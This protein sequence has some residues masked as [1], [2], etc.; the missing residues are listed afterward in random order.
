V[1]YEVK[2][3]TEQEQFRNDILDSVKTNIW[4]ALHRHSVQIPF[5]IRT[6]QL[7][8]QPKHGKPLV[9]TH[10]PHNVLRVKPFFQ[11]LDEEEM[12]RL[13]CGARM[14]RFG[15]GEKIIVQGDEGK[16]MF[17]LVHGSAGV[18]VSQGGG[19][20]HQIATLR[21]G[22]YFGEMSLLTGDP[23]TATIVAQMDCDVLEI[24]KVSFGEIVAENPALLDRLSEVLTARRLEMDG[25]LASKN[26][27]KQIESLQQEYSANLLKRI[28]S[29]FEL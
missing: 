16:S 17:V 21:T 2:F 3:W 29:F 15:R 22:D 9:H 24:D 7:E 4:Y 27:V 13:L 14:L 23:R 10:I 26:E 19:P 6:V 12:Q 25:V 1:V 11:C 28:Y 5:P 18:F 8:R 20:A